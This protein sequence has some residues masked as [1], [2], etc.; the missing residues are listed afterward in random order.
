MKKYIRNF[1]IIAHIDH[2]KSTLSNKIIEIC[3]KKKKNKKKIKILDSM[4][5]E[6]ERGITIKLQSVS[7]NY[8][9]NNKIYKLNLIDTPGHIDFNN[10][11]IRSLH[12]CEGA[13][14]LIDATKGIQAQTIANYNIAKKLN[15]KIIIIINKIDLLYKDINNI[16]NQIK[17]I[18]K[19]KKKNIILCSA[20]KKIGIKK[21]IL[22]II[23]YIPY[24]KVNKKLPL[25]AII[26]DSYFDKYL[27]VFFLIKIING[28]I[29]INDIIKIIN[30]NNKKYNVKIIYIYT[31]KKKIINN[32]YCGEIGWIS[33][34]IKNK[35]YFNP[36]GKTIINY[37]NN[38]LKEIPK[39][40]KTKSKIYAS[41]YPENNKNFIYFKKSIEKLSLNDYSFTFKPE[42]S[43]LLGN[44]FRC[45]FLGILHIE[46][47][48]ERLKKEYNLNIIITSPNVIYKVITKKKKILYIENPNKLPLKNNIKE[49]QEPISIC[50][51]ITPQIFLSKIIKLC[52]NKRGV[53]KKILY[54][55]NNVYL[56]Y[57]LPT[58]EIIT[59]FNNIIKSIS[60]GYA[61]FEYKFKKYKKSNINLLEI[62]INNNKLEGFSVLLNKKDIKK[63]SE[64]IINILKNNIKKQQFEIKIQSKCNNKIISS[65]TIKSFRKNVISKC[66]GGDITRKKKLLN[67]QK[68]GKKKLKKRGNILI[69]PK[70][71]FKILKIKF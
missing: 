6:K 8:K 18:L 1:S 59:N 31:P 21:I 26:I 39:F 63:Y 28:K 47:I 4:E 65:S 7:L 70:I 24:P 60:Q 68:K 36:I 42:N 14:L 16:K 46:I 50:N 2:G 51:I 35:K 13:L 52:L 41:L 33:C 38:N 11:V 23:K 12:I 5:V 15:I 71:Y 57:E 19:I 48:K 55:N 17:N 44:G 49:I 43:Y 37:K 25:K 9:L 10:E 27:G 29:K 45:G 22:N 69:S 3:T 30:F 67:K 54:Y 56:K 66:Y 62:L 40:K 34:N 20:K 64:N 32:L 61:S 58:Y 53:Q